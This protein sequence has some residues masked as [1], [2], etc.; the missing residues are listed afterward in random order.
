MRD[1]LLLYLLS[2]SLFVYYDAN[3]QDSIVHSSSIQ[4]PSVLSAHV[5]GIFMSRIEGH[6][7]GHKS[8][9]FSIQLDYLSANVWGQPVENY[10]PTNPELKKKVSKFPWHTREFQVNKNDE[11]FLNQTEN[12][13]IAYDGVIKGLKAK[14]EIPLNKTNALHLQLRSFVLTNGR[15]PFTGITGDDF[16]E[17]FH[18]NVAGGEDPFQRQAFGLNQ[19]GISYKDRNDNLMKIN[20]NDL[21]FGGIKADFYHYFDFENLWDINFNVGIHPGLNLTSYNQSLD[22]GFS[23]NAHKNFRIQKKSYFQIGLSLGY[24]HLNTISFSNDNIS[25]AERSQFLNIETALTYNFVNSKNH[26]HT[27]GVDFYLQSAYHSPKEYDYSILFRN[28]KALRSWHHSV[29]HLYRNN[30]YWTFF[31]AFT[32]GNSFRIYLQQD[33]NVNNNPDLQTGFG[34]VIYF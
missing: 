13:N 14:V 10:I 3:A 16:I 33:W 6:F 17:A 9:R 18:S 1:R 7:K 2:I 19:A 20:N 31:Y 5:F 30:S 12:F 8:N 22:L 27:F 26:T 29:S 11:S 21:F 25:F 15:L 4:K 34:Y 24:L 23:M 28:D 32:K